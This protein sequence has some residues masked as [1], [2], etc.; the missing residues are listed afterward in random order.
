VEKLY[1]KLADER[2]LMQTQVSDTVGK[3]QQQSYTAQQEL[4]I[5]K[6]KLEHAENAL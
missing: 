4:S 3:A 1:Q 6:L 2:M 5:F